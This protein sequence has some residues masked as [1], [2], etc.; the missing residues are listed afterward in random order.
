MTDFFVASGSPAYRS[1]P[2][3]TS[4]AMRAEFTAIETAMA[5]LAGYTGNG[6]KFLRVNAGGTAYEALTVADALA[7]LAPSSAALAT[8]L[9]DTTGT[10]VF[11]RTQAPTLTSANLVTPVLGTPASGTLTN[12]TGTAAGLTA[13]NVTTNAN[14]TGGVTSVGNAA[15]VVTNANLTGVVTSVG[16]ATTL[17]LTKAQLDTAISDGNAVYVNDTPALVGTNFTG[18]A[19]SLTVG[20][21]T[22]ATNA[23]GSAVVTGA[24]SSSSPSAGIGYAAGAGGSVTQTGTLGS[25]VNL[26]KICGELICVSSTFVAGTSYSFAFTNTTIGAN[27]VVNVSC[28]GTVSGLCI[29]STNVSSAGIVII[30]I[31]AL[32]STTTILKINF[33]VKKCVIS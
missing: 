19:A 14:L 20:T 10:G 33:E 24:I 5:K 21:A 27:D 31:H 22:N 8:A 6:S 1:G 16:N 7:A 17:S 32:I 25:T 18:T 11:V 13:G 23:T 26:N 4:A 15:T 3:G 12:C 29:L 30:D 28:K 2:T 9:T